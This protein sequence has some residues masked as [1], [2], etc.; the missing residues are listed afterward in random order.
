M[1]KNDFK[2]IKNAGS[3]FWVT[4]LFC[5]VLKIFYV[6]SKKGFTL[7]NTDI[8]FLFLF[9]VIPIVYFFMKSYSNDNESDLDNKNENIE[10]NYFK[11]WKEGFAFD[12]VTIGNQI[13]M[14]EDLEEDG[15]KHP[16]IHEEI[17]L[18]EGWRVPTLDDFKELKEFLDNQCGSEFNTVRFLE[19]NWYRKNLLDDTCENCCGKGQISSPLGEILECDICKG[20][21]Y[22]HETDL[23]ELFWTNEENRD[24]SIICAY[25]QKSEFGF[26]SVKDDSVV[27][28]RLIKEC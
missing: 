4:G 24:G 10:P 6:S 27:H 20:T 9:I 14:A 1:K 26:C 11:D 23:C 5:Y 19:K 17:A 3:S 13:W 22:S 25:L 15:S 21:G 2:K 28:L 8:F 18:P 16:Y 7:S 12:T